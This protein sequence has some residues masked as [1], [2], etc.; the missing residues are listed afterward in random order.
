MGR[1]EVWSREQKRMRGEIE[2][3]MEIERRMETSRIPIVCFP[4]VV[5]FETFWNWKKSK[6]MKGREREEREGK[7]EN[8]NVWDWKRSKRMRERERRDRRDRWRP[9]DSYCMFLLFS[10]CLGLEVKRI[11]Q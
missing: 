8:S 2:R 5:L 3:E 10:K 11:E 6:R 4:L 7:G 1:F 9:A